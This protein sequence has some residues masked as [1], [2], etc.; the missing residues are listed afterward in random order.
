ME[1]RPQKVVEAIQQNRKIQA[2]K[3]LRL[4]NNIGLK[5]AKD[6]IDTEFID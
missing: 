4:E 3:L 1:D 2:I 6:A 5:E